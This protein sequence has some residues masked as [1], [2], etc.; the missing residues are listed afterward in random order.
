MLDQSS[1][2]EE[3]SGDALGVGLQD[4]VDAV[5]GHHGRVQHAAQQVEDVEYQQDVDPGVRVHRGP[6]DVEDGAAVT[7]AYSRGIMMK[8]A[9][10]QVALEYLSAVY[11]HEY[12]FMYQ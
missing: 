8:F 12:G 11:F 4:A 3:P 9:N 7:S 6:V 10:I 1:L 5:V 2:R